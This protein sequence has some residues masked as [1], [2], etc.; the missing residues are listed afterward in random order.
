[1]SLFDRRFLLMLPLALAACGFTPVYAPGGAGANLRG[2]VVVQDPVDREGYILL[3]ELETRLGRGVGTYGLAFEMRI[4]DENLGVTR[5]GNITRFNL[6]GT[7]DYSLFD[8]SSEEVIF[9][10]RTHNFTGYSAT[11]DTVETLAAERDARAR[12]ARILADQIVTELYAQVTLPA[13]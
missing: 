4:E 13:Q 11:G 9:A 8:I 1:M 12:L 7:V 10:G 3:Q 5:T 6:V 2:Q